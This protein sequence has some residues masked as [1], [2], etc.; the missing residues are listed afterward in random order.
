MTDHSA[1]V[2]TWR[3]I[4]L[5]IAISKREKQTLAMFS[6]KIP[7]FV[8][9][10]VVKNFFPSL[11]LETKASFLWD[12]KQGSIKLI[13]KR[14]NTTRTVDFIEPSLNNQSALWRQHRGCEG[15][16]LQTQTGFRILRRETT[17][18]SS[19]FPG[20]GE[21]KTSP[22]REFEDKKFCPYFLCG[23]AQFL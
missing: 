9:F 20:Y 14:N 16:S 1:I 18:T 17:G 2:S 11:S 6:T 19:A 15:N 12:K 7:T 3:S 23:L 22:G 13:T 8:M 4:V 10:R 21:A 5:K